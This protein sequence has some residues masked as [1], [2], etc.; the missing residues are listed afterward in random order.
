VPDRAMRSN[1]LRS[2]RVT[3]NGAATIT[4]I[5]PTITNPAIS[6]TDH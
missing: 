5:P 1:S 6:A 3:L 4:G 2:A